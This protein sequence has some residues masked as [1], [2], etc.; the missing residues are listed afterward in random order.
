MDP[1]PGPLDRLAVLSLATSNDQTDDAVLAWPP[2]VSQARMLSP[3]PAPR[4]HRA[5]VSDIQ[6][7][8]SHA[9]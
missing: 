7:D 6:L 2:T 3:K 9:D 5:D 4:R 8:R 1:V